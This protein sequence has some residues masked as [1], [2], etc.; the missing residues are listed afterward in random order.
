MARKII[1]LWILSML[2]MHG[3]GASFK[4]YS[5]R[6]DSVLFD[7]YSTYTFMDFSE[8]NKKSINGMELERIRVAFAREMES[9]GLTFVE[10]SGDASVKIT[11]YHRQ[12]TNGYGYSGRYHYMERAI[13]IDMYDTQLMKHVWHS[14]AVGEL[15]LDPGERAA[16]L[17]QMVEKIFEKYPVAKST[18]GMGPAEQEQKQAKEQ[19]LKQAPELKQTPKG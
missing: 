10:E 11:V 15:E 14:A 6:D 4:L 18:L 2:L 5:D 3:C 19:D 17:P 9:R 7:Q 8:G 16:G 13:A 1:P 12:A